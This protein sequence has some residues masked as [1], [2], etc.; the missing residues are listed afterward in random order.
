MRA[1]PARSAAI[2]RLACI[3]FQNGVNTLKSPPAPVLI[4]NGSASSDPLKLCDLDAVRLERR[5]D[6][7]V[8]LA[9]RAIAPVPVDGLRAGLFDQR[10][11]SHRSAAPLRS[12][13]RPPLAAIRSASARSDLSSHHLLAPPSARASRLSSSST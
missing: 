8:D 7:L 10:R 1:A 6:P 13:S 2:T 12:T 9:R 4:A 3:A 5:L 11:Q